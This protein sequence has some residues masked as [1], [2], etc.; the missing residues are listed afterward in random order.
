MPSPAS[1]LTVALAAT[2][3]ASALPRAASFESVKQKRQASSGDL[4]VD[5]GYEIYEGHLNQ[6]TGINQWNGIR[7]AAPPVGSL[8]WQA[9]QTPAMN[10]SQVIDATN[11][12]NMCV[13]NGDAPSPG[14]SSGSE[15]CLFLN[16]QAPQNA[17][18][19]P[20]FVWI[21]G[22]GYGLGNGRQDLAPIINE[23]GNNF[24]G[25]S[26][27]YRLGAFGFMSSD[28]LFRNGVVNAGLLDQHFALQ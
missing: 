21:H 2:A 5:L 22:G 15:D 6:T 4:R 1:F 16:V 17:S 8:R 12:G 18:N 14:P 3:A 25:V 9:P 20:V 13:Q 27:Q 10:R 28:E 19:L 11:F 24:I 23:N 7:F 26:I